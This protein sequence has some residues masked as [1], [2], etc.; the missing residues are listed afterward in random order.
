MTPPPSVGMTSSSLKTPSSG[1]PWHQDGRD[2]DLVVVGVFDD[3]VRFDPGQGGPVTPGHQDDVSPSRH[4][5]GLKEDTLHS[6]VE[7]AK[8]TTL[9]WVSGYLQSSN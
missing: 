5:T 2:L 4:V 8:H 6:R 3:V 7:T 9:I 1:T